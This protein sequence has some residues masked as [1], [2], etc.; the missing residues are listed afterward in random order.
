MAASASR[1]EPSLTNAQPTNKISF[2]LIQIHQTTI[3][4]CEFRSVQQ[5]GNIG[6]MTRH[7]AKYFFLSQNMKRNFL[8][9]FTS[10]FVVDLSVKERKGEK[11]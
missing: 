7:L 4:I 10:A 3:R 6:L 8:S 1:W 9:N 2:Q 11:Y 5:V